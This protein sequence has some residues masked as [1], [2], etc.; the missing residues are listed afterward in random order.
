MA[1]TA[2]AAREAKP[3]VPEAARNELRHQAALR[4]L[5]DRARRE[6][7]R[8]VLASLSRRPGDLGSA[9]RELAASMDWNEVLPAGAAPLAKHLAARV[10][11]DVRASLIDAIDWELHTYRGGRKVEASHRLERLELQATGPVGVNAVAAPGFEAEVQA[12]DLDAPHSMGDLAR[13]ANAYL[14]APFVS[15]ALENDRVVE[16]HNGTAAEAVASL[17]G[18]GA[19]GFHHLATPKL[20]FSILL[21]DDLRYAITCDDGPDMFRHLQKVLRAARATSGRRIDPARVSRFDHRPDEA[22]YRPARFRR[23]FESSGPIPRQVTIGF[24]NA[25]LGEL[26]ARA[27]RVASV[28]A[29]QASAALPPGFE[30]LRDLDASELLHSPARRAWLAEVEAQ[31]REAGLGELLP[32]VPEVKLAVTDGPDDF[33]DHSRLAY[34]DK[35]G[36]R[37][38]VLLVRNPYGEAAIAMGALFRGCGVEDVLV[39]GT[40]ASLDRRSKVG[41]LHLASQATSPAGEVLAFSNR[42]LDPR[43]KALQSQPGTRSGSRVVNVRSPIDELDS[44]IERLRAEGHDLI[45]MELAGLL[46]GFQGGSARVLAVHVVS[47]VPQSA[48][49]LESFSPARAQTALSAAVDLWVESFGIHD[50]AV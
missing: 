10:R 47:D 22:S 23:C 40:A 30:A 4:E 16:L 18:R 11:E 43:F 25:L 45:E 5:A 35:D 48:D 24:K 7:A 26:A 41:E 37:R 19:T 20:H 36:V 29:L 15:D 27:R 33:L 28:R 9:A 44:V 42:A 39:Y 3:G 32:P 34:L 50:L 17:R 21:G 46:R 38:E 12:I 8:M 6:T 31:A 14:G 2:P 13:Y 1:E 49:T